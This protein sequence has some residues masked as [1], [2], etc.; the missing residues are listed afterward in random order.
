M[1]MSIFL[2]A[3]FT[4]MA[5]SIVGVFL[6]LRKMS[7]MTDAI[8]HT[9]LLGIILAYMI[10][11]D[12][13]SPLLIIGATIIGVTTVY[14]IEMLVKTKRT[15][16]D[17][18]T[19]VVFP[20]LFSI[21]VI[22]ISLGFRNV[23]ID[24]D[25]VLLGSLELADQDSL[26][27]NGINIGPKSLYI[28]GTVFIIN[29]LFFLL[30]YKELKIISFDPALAA[31]LGFM[32]VLIHYLLMTLVSITAVAAFNAV[33]SI[34]V[35]S[36]MVG[37]AMTALL[38]TRNLFKTVIFSMLIGI[39]NSFIGYLIAYNTD[40]SISGMISVVTLAV[41]LIVLFFN[42]KNGVISKIIS[43][44]KQ[45]EDFTLLVLLM[46]IYT[47]SDISSEVKEVTFNNINFELNWKENKTYHYIKLGI[48]NLY[49]EKQ[50]DIIKLTQKGINFHNQ[51]IEEFSS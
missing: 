28:M 45:R 7:M 39:L 31:V 1:S 9:V 8:S 13:S 3:A 44:K 29:L 48:E 36:L 33:G 10:V 49:L 15:S 47:H 46:H 34:L 32:P 27:I 14:L 23:H 26:L 18:A 35:I 11:N 5:S 12:L 37:P 40:L 4:A 22:I 17:A 42:P 50:N 19:G 43:K 51:K 6:V 41:F 2:I 30:L 16:E 24:V 25:A 38:F 21:S 20:L